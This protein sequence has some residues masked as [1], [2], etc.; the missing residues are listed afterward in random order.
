MS[1]TTIAG[2]TARTAPEIIRDMATLICQHGWCVTDDPD[3]QP[4]DLVTA[5]E[6]AVSGPGSKPLTDIERSHI[7]E[8]LDHV[9]LGLGMDPDTYSRTRRAVGCFAVALDLEAVAYKYE[10]ALR[11][12]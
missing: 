9:A 12:A 4:L 8:V 7:S 1:V 11:A 6:W 5:A 2:V 3:A 10:R